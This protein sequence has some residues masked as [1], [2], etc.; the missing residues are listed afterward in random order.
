MRTTRHIVNFK[1]ILGRRHI[2][3]TT[4]PVWDE[5]YLP[6]WTEDAVG[7]FIKLNTIVVLVGSGGS[8]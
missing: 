4:A 8:G 6:V 3:T 5:E 2:T 1:Y 7:R